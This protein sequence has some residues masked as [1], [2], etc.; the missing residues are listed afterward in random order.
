MQIRHRPPRRAAAQRQLCAQ[1][2]GRLLEGDHQVFESAFSR[3]RLH[4]LHV[5]L[6]IEAVP[7]RGRRRRTGQ[8]SL[9]MAFPQCLTTS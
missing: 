5:R 1:D 4:V 8:L 2:S 3:R 7:V 9:F 6:F